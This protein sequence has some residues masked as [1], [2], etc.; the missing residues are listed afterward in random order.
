MREDSPL[1]AIL[2]D[3]VVATCDRFPS[4]NP[5]EVRRTQMSEFCRL[6]SDM[7]GHGAREKRRR[8][9]ANWRPAGDS[10]F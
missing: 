1:H 8:K 10:W 6:L 9:R 4:L 5:F 3:A 7:S 2:F